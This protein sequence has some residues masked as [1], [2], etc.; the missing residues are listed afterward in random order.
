MTLFLLNVS[1]A[2]I[3]HLRLLPQDQASG[4]EPDGNTSQNCIYLHGGLRYYFNDM[5]CE[6]TRP[7]LCEAPLEA[8][9]DGT[10]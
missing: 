9:S 4:L 3:Y 10:A 7:P 1:D 2:I 6:Y 5:G 8:L